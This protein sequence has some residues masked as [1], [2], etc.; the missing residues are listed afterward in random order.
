MAFEKEYMFKVVVVGDNGVGKTSIVRRYVHGIFEE[1]YRAGVG[2]RILAKDLDFE[3]RRVTLSIF[4][5][6]GPEKFRIGENILFKGAEGV[7]VVFDITN[8]NSFQGLDGWFAQLEYNLSER[9]PIIL[10]GNK[11]DLGVLRMVQKEV[12]LEYAQRRGVEYLESSAKTGKNVIKI[13]YELVRRI[14]RSPKYSV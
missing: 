5:I 2:T 12:A 14:L 11:Y 4:E 1:D 8:E 7:V 10:V 3:G 6:G 9:V 13:F